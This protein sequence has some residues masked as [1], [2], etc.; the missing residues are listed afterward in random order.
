M[1][2]LTCLKFYCNAQRLG[3]TNVFWTWAL[4]WFRLL[5]F[6]G[7]VL[8]N[9]WSV[10]PDTLYCGSRY[11]RS[12]PLRSWT[13]TAVWVVITLMVIGSPLTT[14]A[15]SSFWENWVTLQTSPNDKMKT[16]TLYMVHNGC[17]LGNILPDASPL[18]TSFKSAFVTGSKYRTLWM[19]FASL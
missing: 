17:K 15:K 13:V 9:N 4:A 3:D 12:R 5:H 6:A 7:L 11:T 16:I 18:Q 14:A 8:M 10:S 1:P 2:P 19:I